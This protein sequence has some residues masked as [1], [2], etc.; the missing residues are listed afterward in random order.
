MIMIECPSPGV[1]RSPRAVPG[2]YRPSGS[3]PFGDLMTQLIRTSRLG[4]SPGRVLIIRSRRVAC[5]GLYA[6]DCMPTVALSSGS[7]QNRSPTW[8]TAATAGQHRGLSVPDQVASGS[9]GKMRVVA[10]QLSEQARRR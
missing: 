5:A 4:G 3:N 6:G 10:D 2:Q 8:N 1:L 9:I 7:R